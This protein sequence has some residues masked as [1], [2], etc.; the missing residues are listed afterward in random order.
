MVGRCGAVIIAIAKVS[1]KHKK[2][3]GF[4]TQKKLQG[5]VNEYHGFDVSERTIRRDVK[6]LKDDRFLDVTRRTRKDVGEKR[7]FTSNLY[8]LKKKAFIWLD[9]LGKLSDDLFKH[10]HRPKMA[11]NQLLQKRASSL[12]LASS[13]IKRRAVG[14]DG[15]VYE[16]DGVKWDLIGV[17]NEP[18][19]GI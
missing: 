7:V 15:F 10:F 13:V 5:L 12:A 11:N 8:K 18:V 17:P 1:K 14:K 9:S 19:R 16:Y 6:E 4:P 3:Y 2:F